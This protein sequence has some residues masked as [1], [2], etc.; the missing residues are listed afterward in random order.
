MRLSKPCLCICLNAAVASFFPTSPVA[1]AYGADDKRGLSKRKLKGSSASAKSQKSA[2]AECL[3]IAEIQPTGGIAGG[4]TTPQTGPATD[5]PECDIA[6]PSAWNET[7][8]EYYQQP[9]FVNRNVEDDTTFVIDDGT[10]F[11]FGDA[12]LGDSALCGTV[13][14]TSFDATAGESDTVTWLNQANHQTFDPDGAGNMRQ[15]KK[16]TTTCWSACAPSFDISGGLLTL[17]TNTNSFEIPMKGLTEAEAQA[18]LD[19]LK[20][21]GSITW[22]TT[23]VPGIDGPDPA[24]DDAYNFPTDL[25]WRFDGFEIVLDGNNK[26]SARWDMT[27]APDQVV[28]QQ[29]INGLYYTKQTANAYK[30]TVA[31]TPYQGGVT[32]EYFGT[33]LVGHHLM[34]LESIGY[35][36]WVQQCP[37]SA[38]SCPELFYLQV[39]ARSDVA[40]TSPLYDCRF[41][42]LPPTGGSVGTWTTTAFGNIRYLVADSVESM[43]SGECLGATTIQSYIDAVD[44]ID[45]TQAVLGS[46][47]FA[48][49]INIGASSGGGV[50]GC[51]DAVSVD[52]NSEDSVFVYDFE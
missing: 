18:Q 27:Y 10:T 20:A 14:S 33:D 38:P 17:D 3:S 46:T 42:F 32:L 49:V 28:L 26:P 16:V 51:F 6:D 2:K 5:V 34:H 36:F 15:S 25:T 31:T 50:S 35:S 29:L 24:L 22:T 23:A 13:P 21:I 19:E 7:L 52:L 44:D 39:Y 30:M 37:A 11:V 48:F 45:G 40:N 8:C 4:P 47:E 43:V 1:L 41:T 12:P 9:F